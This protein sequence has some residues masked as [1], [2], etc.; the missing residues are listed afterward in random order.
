MLKELMG[1][2]CCPPVT[3]RY[4]YERLKMPPRYRGRISFKSDLCVGCKICV[5]DCPSGAIEIVQLPGDKYQFTYRSLLEQKKVSLQIDRGGK[6]RFKAVFNLGKCLFC[7][8]CVES[9]PR[10]A[11]FE[12]DDYELAVLDKEKLFRSYEETGHLAEKV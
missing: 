7:A 5:R 6:K 3:V 11:L 9:C 1:S 12:T 2:L 10:K 8:Q 4:P